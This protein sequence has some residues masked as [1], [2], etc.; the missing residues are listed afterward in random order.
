MTRIEI[1]EAIQAST[2]DDKILLLS[3][4]TYNSLPITADLL[5][6][7]VPA[8]KNINDAIE[9]IF[10]PLRIPFTSQTGLTINWQTDIPPGDSVSYFTLFGNN[11]EAFV[12]TTI[13]LGQPYTWTIDGSNNILLVTFDWGSSQS[14][15]IR[16]N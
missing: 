2:P 13:P 15:Y 6:N 16:F 14:G 3:L 8:W 7:D 1:I 12:Y 5:D 9:N 10:I 4:L 11:I